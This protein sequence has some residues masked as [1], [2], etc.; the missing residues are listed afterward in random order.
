MTQDDINLLSVKEF[1]PAISDKTG[2]IYID[3]DGSCFLFSVKSDAE[4]MFISNNDIKIGA[5]QT[6]KH[7]EFTTGYYSKGI[8]NIVLTEKGKNPRK[9]SVDKSH[10]AKQF[11]NPE[12]VFVLIRLKE[13]SQK[14]YLKQLGKC[15]F[16]TPLVLP[17]RQ[18]GK[19]PILHYCTANSKDSKAF[20]LL[21]STLQEFDQW[22]NEKQK[23]KWLAVGTSLKKFSRVYKS[24]DVIIDPLGLNILLTNKQLAYAS[25]SSQQ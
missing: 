17:P 22:N 14:R 11:Y 24:K 8:K 4:Q 25:Q 12:A 13:T 15:T 2:D 7:A 10:A 21:F 5:A 20:H 19:Y 3:E 1:Y 23:G 18:S 16:Y 6:I 9:I